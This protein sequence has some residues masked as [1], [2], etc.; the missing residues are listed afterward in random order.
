MDA[1]IVVSMGTEFASAKTVMISNLK[2]LMITFALSMN[3]TIFKKPGRRV[4][5]CQVRITKDVGVSTLLEVEN[6][7]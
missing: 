1:A 5:L 3:P 4:K 6:H 2:S 7:Q